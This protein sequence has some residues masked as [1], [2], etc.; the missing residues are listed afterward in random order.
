VVQV[1][2]DATTQVYIEPSVQVIGATGMFA[3]NFERYNALPIDFWDNKTTLPTYDGASVASKYERTNKAYYTSTGSRV[4]AYTDATSIIVEGSGIT[5]SELAITV[6]GKP[7]AYMPFT[8]NY[9]ITMQQ[10]SLPAGMK[11]IEI[12]TGDDT[13]QAASWLRAVYYSKLS[14][15]MIVPPS[16]EGRLVIYGDS[17]AAGSDATH[18]TTQGWAALLRK[19]V[20]SILMEVYG[21]RALYDDCSTA[22]ATQNFAN[23]IAS[24]NPSAIWIELGTNDYGRPAWSAANYGIAYAALLA[25]LHAALPGVIIYCQSPTTACVETANT[26]GNTLGDYRAQVS[27]AVSTINASWAVFVDGTTLIGTGDL[28][29]PQPHPTTLGHAKIYNAILNVLGMY[30]N[31]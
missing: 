14:Y 24:Y 19:N 12:I 6:N 15:F 9:A 29:S 28:V 25:D 7:Y 10:I 3:S 4:V 20:R 11:K 5:T 21:G 2:I 18:P 27:T 1:I 23:L 30:R 8:T 26:F 31:S 16:N 13:F 17:I 22:A